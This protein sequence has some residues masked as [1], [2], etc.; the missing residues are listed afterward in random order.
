MALQAPQLSPDNI[1]D[2]VAAMTLEEKAAVLV[3]GGSKAFNGIGN[4]DKGVPGAAGTTHA[5]PRLGIPSVVLADGPAGLRINP[6]REGEEK[7][8]YCTGFPIGTMLAST[9]NTELVEEVGRAM[10]NE[11]LEYGVDVILGPGVNIHRNPLCGR[12]TARIRCLPARWP[13]R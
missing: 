7:T 4:T 1:R 6:E 11:V 5:V 13:R 9:W 8:F 2:V 3:G 12:I 10:G